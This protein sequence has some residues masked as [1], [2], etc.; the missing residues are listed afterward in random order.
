VPYFKQILTAC[1]S[2]AV[3]TLLAGCAS[4]PIDK[5]LLA[6]MEPKQLILTLARD[7]PIQIAFRDNVIK[8][9]Q[10][11]RTGDFIAY[12]VYYVAHGTGEDE[13]AYKQ[14]NAYCTARG[15][16][17]PDTS[18]G[19]PNPRNFGGVSILN[20][21]GSKRSMVPSTRSDCLSLSSG[22]LLFST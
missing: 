10:Q 11:I 1:G 18:F 21:L 19:Q 3:F 12:Q 16:I 9:V 15:G 4:P 22:R 8:T 17:F 7:R 5:A 13:P 20:V 2:S 6:T 14:I